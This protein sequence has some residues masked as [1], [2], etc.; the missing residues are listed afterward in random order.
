MGV[1][2]HVVTEYKDAEGKWV[3]ADRYHW[4][5]DSD[6]ENPNK[7]YTLRSVD[8]YPG[9]STLLFDF[10][11]EKVPQ[12]GKPTDA[13]AQF[14]K[15]YNCYD[16]PYKVN[17][18]TL[19]ELFEVWNSL[20]DDELFNEHPDNYYT[21]SNGYCMYQFFNSVLEAFSMLRDSG[22]FNTVTPLNDEMDLRVLYFF[23]R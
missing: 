16:R 1:D 3:H 5:N 21:Y 17:Y 15:I 11:Q 18:L 14:W 12:H 19:K 2:I 22:V 20:V 23:E 4:V 8:L 10:L 13:C 9:R 6:W 7:K